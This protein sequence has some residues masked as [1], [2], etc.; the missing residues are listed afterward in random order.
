MYH[1]QTLSLDFLCS[2]VIYEEEAGYS[3]LVQLFTRLYV[4]MARSNWVCGWFGFK[5]AKQ[6][7]MGFL[8]QLSTTTCLSLIVLLNAV[9]F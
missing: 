6:L 7:K 5:I 8:N 2:L 3:Q 1:I 4:Q 9:S